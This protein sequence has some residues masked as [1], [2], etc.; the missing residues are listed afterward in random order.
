MI[1]EFHK[2]QHLQYDPKLEAV[3]KFLH[4]LNQNLNKLS[5]GALSEQNKLLH[6]ASKI[7]DKQSAEPIKDQDLFRRMHM[8]QELADLMV[9][10]AGL[11]VGLKHL[12]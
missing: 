4:D 2:V 7:N 11:S 6:L 10:H 9:E 12:L 1:G 8:Y 3:S 5:P